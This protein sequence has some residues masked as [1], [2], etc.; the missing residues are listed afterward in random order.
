MERNIKIVKAGQVLHSDP[1][2]DS[3]FNLPHP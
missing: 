1:F 3:S 2:K